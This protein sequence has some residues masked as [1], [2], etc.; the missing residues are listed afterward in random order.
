MRLRISTCRL[1]W[2]ACA[3]AAVVLGSGRRASRKLAVEAGFRA[4][5]IFPRQLQEQT[6]SLRREAEA[7]ASDLETLQRRRDRENQ[8]SA[9][10]IAMLRSDVDLSHGQR[11]VAPPVSPPPRRVASWGGPVLHAS[12]RV[13]GSQTSTE[14]LGDAQTPAPRPAV[15]L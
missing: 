6:L 14:V 1:G 12:C 3:S 2:P 5:A 13:K 11:S 9:N 7:R 4:A 15:L 10:L 8:E